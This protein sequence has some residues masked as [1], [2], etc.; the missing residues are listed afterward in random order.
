MS[1]QSI[2]GRTAAV[3]AVVLIVVTALVACSPASLTA[4]TA[5]PGNSARPGHAAADKAAAR[6]PAGTQAQPVSGPGLPP[7]S[8]VAPFAGRALAGAGTWHPAGRRVDGVPAVYETLL[9]PPGGSQPAGLAWMDTKLLAARLYS[10]PGSPGGTSW[11]FTAPV[12]PAQADTLVAAFNGGF[13]MSDGV[14][15]YYSEGRMAKPLVR[16]AA[17]L[18]IYA[19][20]GVDVGE[21]GTDMTWVPSIVAVR[22]N[23]VPLVADGLPTPAATSSNWIAWGNTCGTDSCAASVP[24][25]EDQWRSAVGVTSDGALVYA[26]GPGL[27]PLQLAQVLVRAGVVRAME[28]DINPYWPV[29]ATYAPARNGRAA[30]SNGTKL[31]ATI[32]GPATFFDPQWNRDFITMS[33]R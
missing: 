25:V 2:Q 5:S 29:F 21:W 33:A 20:G 11:K 9:L 28:L 17:S 7:P 24:D 31:L 30:P 13:K 1:W 22:Q 15:G 3:A 16:G 19:G 6:K 26:L 4:R 14:G 10:G 12:K 8:S 32:Q 27:S 18:V 23:L